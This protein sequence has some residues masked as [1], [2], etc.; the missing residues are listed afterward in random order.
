M[1]M[2][3]W[4]NKDEVLGEVTRWGFSLQYASDELRN[5]PVIVLVAV[6]E[7]GLAL[8]FAT[9]KMKNTPSIVV[10]AF[11]NRWDSLKHAS[12]YILSDKTFT[13]RVK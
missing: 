4:N 9:D 3:D 8:E 11:N 10:A 5:D 13:M 6:E 2:P 12:P 7:N 1:Y